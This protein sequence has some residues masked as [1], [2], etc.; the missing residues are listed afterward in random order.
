MLC[1]RGDEP[2]LYSTCF[3]SALVTNDSSSAGNSL[4]KKPLT[5]SRGGE[6]RG[7]S[8]VNFLLFCNLLIIRIIIIVFYEY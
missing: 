7:A 3:P 6:G 5:E 1:H 2:K 8:L 4:P